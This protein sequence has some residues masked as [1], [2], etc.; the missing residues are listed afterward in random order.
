[1][2]THMTYKATYR[3]VNIYRDLNGWYIAGNLRSDTFKGIKLLINKTKQ[4]ENE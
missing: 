2:N 3:K 4:N 1:M